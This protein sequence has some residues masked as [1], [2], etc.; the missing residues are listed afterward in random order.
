MHIRLL[1]LLLFPLIA[2]GQ[3]NV[4][5]SSINQFFTG[6]NYKFNLTGGDLNER[7]GFNSEIGMDFQYKFKNNLTIGIDGGFIFGNQLKDT[8]IFEDSYNSFNTITGL[9]G[10][11]A[12]VLFLMRGAHG[13]IGAGY[14]FNKL[15]NNPNSGLWINAGVGYFMHKIRIESLYDEVPQLE[16]DYR[17]GYDRL[18]MGFATK[19]FI[20]YLFQHDYRFLNFY[21]GFEFIQG[22]TY[23]VRNYNFDIEG[24][25]PGMKLDFMYSVKFGWMI[26]IYKRQ[27]K[28]VYYD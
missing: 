17:K 19:Q 16:G 4:R 24:P 10:S 3:L 23:N 1:C 6:I 28:P 25:D 2:N 12:T 21:A 8:V 22:F 14:I 15:G 11:P 26:P 9:N 20:G 18:T 27:P 7:W 13:N 5:D